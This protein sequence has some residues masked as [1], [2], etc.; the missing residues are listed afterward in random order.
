ML[1]VEPVQPRENYAQLVILT[2]DVEAK[3]RLEQKI[4]ELAAREIP[5]AVIYSKSIPLGPPSAYP[6]ML[7]V[8][9]P[10]ETMAKKYARQVR[11]IALQ[12]PAVTMTRFDW[13]EKTG[14]VKVAI[15]ND[16]LRQMGIDRQT[17][18]VA[19]QA[20]LSGYTVAQ[21]YEG[22]QAIDLV[23]RLDAADRDKISDLRLLSIPTS[24]GSVPLA[25]V[26]NISYE[27]EDNMIW[28]R[29]LLP[30]VT[31]NAGIAPG[32]TGNDVT[33][34]IY[35][36]LADLRSKLPP[37]ASIEIGGPLESSNKALNY[38]LV[39]IPVMFI[40]MIVLL[41]LQLKDIRK[42]FII[43]CTAPM[44]IIGVVLGLLLFNSS[45]GFLAQLGIL[46]LTGIIIR[47]S[48]VL[49]D[50]IDLHL[51]AGMQPYEAVLESAIVRFRPI[52]LAALTTVLGLVPMFTNPF[53]ESM[54]VAIACG[55][56]GA[57]LLTLV[58]L[59]VIYSLMFKITKA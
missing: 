56:T 8:S 3:N 49:I 52:M 6:V 21:Y 24:K 32:Y 48:V 23:F 16:K 42:L 4:N 2:K 5:E 12:N 30:T 55:L 18:A 58:V 50:Q 41:M 36:S 14:A 46:S 43:V 28:R 25:Q 54:A 11:E 9:A 29:N 37:G 15:D 53:W 47:N 59:P 51:A 17:V 27:A 40:T 7:R 45:M 22:D 13:M 26:A 34:Q 35:N 10:T 39:P 19:L 31:V 1:V 38:L 44:G 20:E 33:Q 57:T